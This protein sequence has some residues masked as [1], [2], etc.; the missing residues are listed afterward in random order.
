MAEAVA[1]SLRST[2]A[3]ATPIEE[4]LRLAVSVLVAPDD[5]VYPNRHRALVDWLLNALKAK[6]NPR[7]GTETTPLILP[8]RADV[9]FWRLLDA[10]LHVAVGSEAPD[11]DLAPPQHG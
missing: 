2:G 11:D 5:C 7:S 1:R 4:K 3:G 8:P 6:G 9:R 10:L